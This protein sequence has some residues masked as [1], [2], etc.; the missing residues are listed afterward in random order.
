MLWLWALKWSMS[1]GVSDRQRE[2]VFCKNQSDGGRQRCRGADGQPARADVA[3]ARYE[4]M[5][6]AAEQEEERC[7]RD[8]FPLTGRCSVGRGGCRVWPGGTAVRKRSVGSLK[9]SS[10]WAS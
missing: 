8:M 9:L 5:G 3:L 6:S 7:C 1:R 10:Y 4:A 2:W